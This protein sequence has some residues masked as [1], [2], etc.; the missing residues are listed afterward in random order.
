MRKYCGP[1]SRCI[2][3]QPRSNVTWSY[4]VRVFYCLNGVGYFGQRSLGAAIELRGYL[5]SRAPE[6]QLQVLC[7]ADPS[8][9]A[10]GSAHRALEKF[11]LGKNTS[12]CET[13]GDLLIAIL[14]Q[15]AAGLADGDLFIVHDCSPTWVHLS[16]TVLL[17]NVV[18]SVP[19]LSSRIR[20]LVEKPSVT[21]T[22]MRRRDNE[23]VE[24][25]REGLG[26][27]D[28]IELQSLTYHTARKWLDE[29]PDF[30]I[31]ELEVWRNSGTGFKKTFD[32]T[33]KGVTGGALEDKAAHD[34]AL[35]MGLVG[36]PR[37]EPQVTEAAFE[38]FL[39]ADW[40]TENPKPR[41]ITAD[42]E[43]VQLLDR[44]FDPTPAVAMAGELLPPDDQP[45][46]SVPFRKRLLFEVADSRVLARVR[47]PIAGGRVVKCTYHFSWD[48]VDRSLEERL[49]D[50]G[51]S[52]PVVGREVHM[53][54]DELFRYDVNEARVHILSARPV[55]RGRPSRHIVLNFLAKHE[56]DVPFV[57]VLESDGTI[58][59]VPLLTLPG[60]RN[61]IFRQLESLIFDPSPLIGGL[62]SDVI[63]EVVFRIRQTATDVAAPSLEDMP[64]V[65]R[66]V[67]NSFME[68][69]NYIH[70]RPVRG[71]I[72]DLDN[73]LIDTLSL[74][75]TALAPVLDAIGSAGITEHDTAWWKA[76]TEN[77]KWR[78]LDDVAWRSVLGFSEGELAAARAALMALEIA[79]GEMPAMFPDAAIALEGLQSI[80]Q[81]HFSSA[82]RVEC[83]I[84]TTGFRR[85]QRAK[86]DAHPI[87]KKVFGT[88]I[89]VDD[90]EEGPGRPGHSVYLREIASRW[91]LS[92]RHVLVVGDNPEAE[93]LAA[94]NLGMRTA[95]VKRETGAGRSHVAQDE[96][97][98]VIADLREVP[99]R[100]LL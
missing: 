3:S 98:P 74:S 49:A 96:A 64:G 39:P 14:R 82:G 7:I 8:A 51:L 27:C 73:T 32:G 12:L 92:S 80:Q 50:L 43:I 13:F 45:P 10:R 58:T 81:S 99:N 70:L 31:G 90:L 1:P 21:S 97:H 56:S 94:L 44:S 93:L 41:F 61:S 54:R 2:L 71:V 16:N 66:D 35:T 5:P 95:L 46:D 89:F 24:K 18:A 63:N 78:P 88:N 6:A 87:L 79:P 67:T 30:E 83:A 19:A 20:Y 57:C 68:R 37:G 77:L 28:Y 91:G 11:G 85:L 75:E 25:L 55:G 23:D 33:R 4:T 40:N 69:S 72:F 34:L 53:G 84:L 9:E 17:N 62:A 86:I 26:F 48:G 76:V 42:D 38:N 59:E 22:Q 29:H 47:W 52:R 36:S 15:N 60:G 65:M 100:L